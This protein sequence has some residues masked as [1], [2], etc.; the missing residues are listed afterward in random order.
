[1]KYKELFDLLSDSM[2]A[3]N[4]QTKI[5]VDKVHTRIMSALIELNQGNLE[6]PFVDVNG[7]NYDVEIGS[8]QYSG[9]PIDSD[10]GQDMRL[11]FPLGA[12]MR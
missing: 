4:P 8:L 6:L 3:L 10:S 7:R 5:D 9:W 11:A 1:M 2:L 12:H